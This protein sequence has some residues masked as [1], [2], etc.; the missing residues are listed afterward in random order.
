[1]PLADWSSFLLCTY[2][3]QTLLSTLV[4]LEEDWTEAHNEVVPQKS[5]STQHTLLGTIFL[6]LSRRAVTGRHSSTVI[7]CYRNLFSLSYIL[8]ICN[9]VKLDTDVLVIF[10]YFFGSY[11]SLE[12]FQKLLS[13]RLKLMKYYSLPSELSY[14]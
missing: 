12:I 8:D 11:M 1:M 5:C 10:E 14:V 6:L 4:P 13:N 9:I 3:V 7:H 2:L